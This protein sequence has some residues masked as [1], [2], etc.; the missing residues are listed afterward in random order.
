MIVT[1][2]YIAINVDHKGINHPQFMFLG[3]STYGHC[4]AGQTQQ[5]WITIEY[6]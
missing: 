2:N 6:D 5:M 1:K 3:T 4:L